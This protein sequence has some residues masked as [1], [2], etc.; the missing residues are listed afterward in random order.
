MSSGENWPQM[1]AR[2][3]SFNLQHLFHL[4]CITKVEYCRVTLALCF[5]LFTCRAVTVSV[6]WCD[7]V[8]PGT[9]VLQRHVSFF[10]VEKN[11]IAKR[12]HTQLK[13]AQCLCTV[14]CFFEEGKQKQ[15]ATYIP[16]GVRV[17][18]CQH[19]QQQQQRSGGCPGPAPAG[20][21]RLQRPQPV[22]ARPS[23]AATGGRLG[24]SRGEKGQSAARQ[25]GLRESV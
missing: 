5:Y 10:N 6:T 3:C 7:T 9:G 4:Y 12:T 20:S 13:E 23:P 22:H 14:K 18:G 11:S 24:E 8:T 16:Y 1:E 25:P 21:R 2:N 15:L 17:P 19:Q